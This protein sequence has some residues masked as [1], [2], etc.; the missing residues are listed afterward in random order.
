MKNYLLISLISLNLITSLSLAQEVQLYTSRSFQSLEPIITA[1]HKKTGVNIKV[2]TEKYADLLANLQSDNNIADIALVVDAGNLAQIAQLGLFQAYD[3]K[4]LTQNIPSALRDP[5]N[6]WFGLSIRARTIFYNPKTVKPEELSSYAALADISWKGKLCLRSP[7]SIYNKSLI[8][9]HIADIGEEHTQTMLKGWVANL[10][11][12]PEKGIFPNDTALLEAIATG[13]CDIGITN[14]YYYNRILEKNP[15]FPVKL[16]WANQA[17]NG[18]HVNVL[19]AG[20]LKNAKNVDAARLFLDWLSSNTGQEILAK[21]SFEYSINP[22]I[23]ANPK[24]SILGEF[25]Q[26]SLNLSNA[27]IYQDKAIEIMNNA[28]YKD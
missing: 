28:G 12:T 27:W 26:N 3:S 14:H 8:A 7:K 6:L 21:S 23:A 17:T 13:Q 1:Y 16:F 15:D 4:A 2:T 19:G 25:K 10:A 20:I 9:T 5:A 24:V 11:D 22:A 18:T